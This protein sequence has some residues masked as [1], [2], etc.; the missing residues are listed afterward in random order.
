VKLNTTELSAY[1]YMLTVVFLTFV[2]VKIRMARTVELLAKRV[3]QVEKEWEAKS[4][5]K[6]DINKGVHL[7]VEQITISKGTKNE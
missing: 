3:E 4:Y 2:W 5:G 1:V 7:P 6:V